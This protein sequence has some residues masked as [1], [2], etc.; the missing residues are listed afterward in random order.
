MSEGTDAWRVVALAELLHASE[1][2]LLGVVRTLDP[3]MRATMPADARWVL[4]EADAETLRTLL[5][6]HADLAEQLR[7]LAERIPDHGVTATYAEVRDG[8]AAA[9]ADGILDPQVVVVTAAALDAQTGWAALADA[10][11]STDVR[12]AWAGLGCRELLVAFRG[13]DRHLVARALDRAEVDPEERWPDLG[14][15]VA[16]RLA[17][18][19]RECASQS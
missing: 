6:E 13:V 7:A 9:L 12:S 10:L 19:L 2:L 16:L 8:A 1:E 4:S 18:A 5:G 11:V 3:D 15:H 14:T 17:R